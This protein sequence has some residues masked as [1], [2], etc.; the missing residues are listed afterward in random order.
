MVGSDGA[1]QVS[2]P[3]M[4]PAGGA[5]GGEEGPGLGGCVGNPV[6]VGAG[7]GQD[8]G[9]QDGGTPEGGAGRGRRRLRSLRPGTGRGRG[10]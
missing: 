10:P 9:T 7:V 2:K 1:P 3:A 6:P 8:G 5:G 4:A